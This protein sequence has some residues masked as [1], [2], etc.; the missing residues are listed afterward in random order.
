MDSIRY[1]SP[2]GKSSLV[3]DDD[4]KTGYAYLVNVDGEITADCWLYNRGPAPTESEWNSPE[5]MPFANPVE[6]VEPKFQDGF[7]PPSGEG[8]VSVGWLEDGA[9]IFIEGRLFA[10]RRFKTGLVATGN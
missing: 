8:D 2:D 9:E 5:N 7:A 3:L 4:G 10:P 1:T 6:Y